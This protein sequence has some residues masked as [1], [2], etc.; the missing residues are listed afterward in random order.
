MA[1]QKAKGTEDFYPEEEAVKQSLF[2]TF[3]N[4][5][6][7][8]NFQEVSTPAFEDLDLLS[9]KEGEEIKQQIFRFTF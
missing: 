2:N 3:R 7:E 6:K 9:K 1:V 5:A 4:V 8:F